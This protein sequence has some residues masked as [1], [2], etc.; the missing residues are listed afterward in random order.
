MRVHVLIYITKE[1]I[2]IMNILKEFNLFWY[3][4][5]NMQTHKQR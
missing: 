5:F 2:V 3:T 1:I 4:Q